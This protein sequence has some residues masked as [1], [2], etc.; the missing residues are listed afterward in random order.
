MDLSEVVEPMA[1]FYRDSKRLLLK[2]SKPD[3][4]GMYFL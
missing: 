1:E 3:A 2:C 4:K